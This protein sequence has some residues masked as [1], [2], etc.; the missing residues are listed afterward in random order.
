MKQLLILACLIFFAG[1]ASAQQTA[2]CYH[3]K[4][5]NEI[6][7]H[8]GDSISVCA[9]IIQRELADSTNTAIL[10]LGGSYPH[11]LL[12]VTIQGTQ[13]NRLWP[14]FVPGVDV[15]LTGKLFSVDGKPELLVTKP[16]QLG[17]CGKLD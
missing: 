9:L 13:N 11:H 5:L 7:K 3:F 16:E 17:L 4:Q 8:L 12:K 2:I 6:S 10:Y 14:G 15:Y 1:K